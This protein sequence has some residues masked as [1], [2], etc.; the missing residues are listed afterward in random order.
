MR[1]LIMSTLVGVYTAP[2]IYYN[3]L[4]GGAPDETPLQIL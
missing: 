4:S 3:T 2:T 1:P